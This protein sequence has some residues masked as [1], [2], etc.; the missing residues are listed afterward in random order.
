[1]A[2]IDLVDGPLGVFGDEGVGV[3]GGLLEG[4]EVVHGAGVAE[5]HADVAEEAFAFDA[6]DGGFGEEGAEVLDG[7]GEEVAEGVVEDG[8]AGVEAGLAAEFGE[9]V[10]GADVEAVVAAVDAV[11]D[12]GA[13]VEGDGALV[14]DGEVGDAAGGVEVVGARDGVGGAGGH[15]GGAFAA[16]VVLLFVGREG[17]GGEEFGEEEPGA[18]GGVDLDGGLAVPAEAGFGGE[19]A[20]ED[21]AGVGVV[22]LGA[23]HVLEG[24]VEVAEFVLDEV[25]V[26]VVPGVT[27]DAVVWGRG[28]LAAGRRR[29]GLRRDAAATV[30]VGGVAGVVV[31]GEGD[32]GL[33]AGE[34]FA[35]V[36][37]AFEVA[38]EPF[39]VAGLAVGDPLEVV[40]GVGGAGGGGNT[41]VI[42]AELGGDVAD[43]GFGGGGVDGGD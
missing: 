25:V 16:V 43:V 37:A 14:F 7:E 5:G 12:E 11:A 20:F 27:G 35:G 4:G 26:V 18:E 8:F 15:A 24:E 23:A 31:E 38:L 29:N 17:K 30:M 28:I 33:G 6:F 19:V 42:E 34:D 9:A 3:G 2:G 13:E 39:H 1:M 32:D 21:G 36:A 10:P 41:A 40:V 22:A